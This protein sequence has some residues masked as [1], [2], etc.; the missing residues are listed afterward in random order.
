MQENF[1]PLVQPSPLVCRKISCVGSMFLTHAGNML[2]TKV[3]ESF[4]QN[5]FLVEHYCL[6]CEHVQ[7][8][9]SQNAGKFLYTTGQTV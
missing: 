3:P 9:F 1:P 8:I 2:P 4:L 7:E 6:R 5:V